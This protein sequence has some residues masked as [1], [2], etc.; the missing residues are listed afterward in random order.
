M[1]EKEI[2]DLEAEKNK[3]EMSLASLPFEEI[4]KASVRIG[5]IGALLAD[6]EMHW[7]ELSELM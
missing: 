2:K 1:L 6:K 4:Q 7:L 3:L 5:E